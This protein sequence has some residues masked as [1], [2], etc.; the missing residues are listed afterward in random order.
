MSN[1]I[2]VMVHVPFEY[3][4]RDQLVAWLESKVPGAEISVV[5]KEISEPEVA[6]TLVEHNPSAPPEETAAHLADEDSRSV[7]QKVAD[8]LA[9]F[10]KQG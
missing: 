2:H 3:A 6:E 10:G 4:R 8:A 9:E 7:M 5:H 1:S